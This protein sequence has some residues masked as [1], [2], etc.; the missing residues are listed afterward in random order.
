M[1]LSFPLFL[2]IVLIVSS[3]MSDFVFIFVLLSIFVFLFLFIP[4]CALDHFL[5]LTNLAKHVLCN[6]IDAQYIEN[7]L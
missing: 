5:F 3:F 6:Q 1:R 7:L 2:G 4:G